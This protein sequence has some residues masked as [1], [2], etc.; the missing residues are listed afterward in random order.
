MAKSDI[1]LLAL[2][3]KLSSR[4]DKIPQ[5]ISVIKGPQGPKGSTGPQGIQGPKG[6]RGLQGPEG[7]QGPKGDKGDKGDQGD[8]G[9]GVQEVYEAADGEIV[10]VFT[11]GSEHSIELPLSNFYEDKIVNYVSTVQAQAPVKFTEVTTTPYY[12][13]QAG[14]IVG[15]NIFGVST[16]SDAIV[17]LPEGKSPTQLIVIN[18]EMQTYNVTILTY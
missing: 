12:I 14:L 11:D 9:I 3:D 15:H 10:F 4:I 2:Y 17:H 16:G 8:A 7:T 18:N 13:D 5:Q 6:D 1:K